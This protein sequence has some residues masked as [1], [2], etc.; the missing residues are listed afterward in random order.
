MKTLVHSAIAAAGLLLGAGVACAAS[1]TPVGSWKQVDDVTGMA[2]SII[3]ISEDHGEL[4]GKIVQL[5]NLTPEEIAQDGAHPLCGKCEGERKDQPIEGMVIMWGV[6]RDSDVWT[7]GK[8]LDPKSGS[9]YKV[10]LSLSDG[11]QKLHVRGY[12]GLS[13]LGRSQTWVRQE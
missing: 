7:G 8:I 4:Q 5:M 6:K 3:Q 11:G 10:K 12:I 13:L 1:E 2:K 9:V